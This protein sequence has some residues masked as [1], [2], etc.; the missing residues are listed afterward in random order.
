M[1][2]GTNV[3]EVAERMMSAESSLLAQC[4]EFAKEKKLTD[5]HRFVFKRPAYTFDNDRIVMVLG[6]DLVLIAQSNGSI[7]QVLEQDVVEVKVTWRA[8]DDG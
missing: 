1:S 5:K 3:R 7:P 2:I 4:A 8:S 6:A